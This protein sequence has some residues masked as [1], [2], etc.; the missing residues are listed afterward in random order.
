MKP[1]TEL[2]ILKLCQG[3]SI[4][5]ALYRLDVMERYAAQKALE[6]RIKI[7]GIVHG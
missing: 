6:L 7:Q 2:K 1:D 5:Q 4:K 3:M